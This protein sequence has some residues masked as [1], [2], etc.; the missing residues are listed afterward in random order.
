MR[1]GTTTD[2]SAPGRACS[3]LFVNATRR[4]ENS[5]LVIHEAQQAR[6]PVITAA[7]GGMAEFVRHAC[8]TASLRGCESSD[9]SSPLQHLSHPDRDGVN[10]LTYEHRS[11]IGLQ[12]ALQRGF[13]DQVELRRLGERGYLYSEDGN[14]RPSTHMMGRLSPCWISSLSA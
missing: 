13:D 1:S 9:T 6:I 4:E 10:G 8:A 7:A 5:P 14:V 11:V 12:A 3:V 2:A